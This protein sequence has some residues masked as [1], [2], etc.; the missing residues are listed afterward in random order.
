MDKG[1]WSAVQNPE[2]RWHVASDDFK[3]DVW[4]NVNGDFGDVETRKAYCE[5]LAG[6]LNRAAVN[7]RASND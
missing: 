3:H 2:G 5:W 7:G 6:Q 1:P 4:L